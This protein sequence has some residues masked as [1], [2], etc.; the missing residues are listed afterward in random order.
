MHE[1]ESHSRGPYS[2]TFNDER[3]GDQKLEILM[4]DSPK[5]GI[6]LHE[7]A[8]GITV[9]AGTILFLMDIGQLRIQLMQVYG[10]LR[11]GFVTPILD[12]S[13]CGSCAAHAASSAIESC[14]AIASSKQIPIIVQQS[15]YSILLLRYIPR[16]EIP[17]TVGGLYTGF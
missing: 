6:A 5:T 8:G 11:S 13:T 14:L 12:Q 4:I 7:Q 2:K 16:T 3:I 10:C 9:P 17:A 15:V 1:N